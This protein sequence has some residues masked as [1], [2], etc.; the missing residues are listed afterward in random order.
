[1]DMTFAFWLL[2]PLVQIGMAALF[3]FLLYVVVKKAVKKG[4]LEAY[5][6]IGQRR[7]NGGIRNE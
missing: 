5:G 1:M 3:F 2:A 4:I 6:E 7:E